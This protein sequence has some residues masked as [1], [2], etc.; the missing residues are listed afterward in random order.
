MS[1]IQNRVYLGELSYGKDRRYINTQAHEPIVD[2]ATWIAAQH[3]R[4]ARPRPPRAGGYLLTGL[5]PCQSCGYTMQGTKT[6]RA[7]RVYRCIRRHAGGTCPHPTWA[8]ADAVE[9]AAQD[10]FWAITTNFQATAQ[11]KDRIDLQ[12][13]QMKFDEADRRLAQALEPEVQ[14]A[15]GD[16][17]ARMIK[18]RR[19]DRDKTA[20]ALGQARAHHS[21]SS[22]PI[23]TLKAEWPSLDAT[24]KR[25][26]LAA[27][28]DALVLSKNNG[29]LKLA[30]FPAGTGPS[31]LSRRGFRR[32][33]G[34][35]P[36]DVPAG[37]RILAL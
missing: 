18:Q 34:L 30:V 4:A 6:S 25:Q 14:D 16:D 19:A 11:P 26:L 1:L 10:E 20:E 36:I 35:H 9:R 5:L 3:P 7:K 31:G 22:P 12:E 33:P 2:L 8:F 28:F 13:L 21:E 29:S 24:D 37:T 23:K 17:W 27:R 15:A 32:N